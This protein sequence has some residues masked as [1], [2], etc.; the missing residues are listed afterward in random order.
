MSIIRLDTAEDHR[1]AYLASRKLPAGT[2]QQGR[3]IPRPFHETMPAEACTELGAEPCS[4]P[5]TRVGLILILL[6][7][8]LVAV[9]VAGSLA[10]FWPA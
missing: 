8:P 7:W 10:V 3:Y 1:A 4:P 5:V 2:D 6:G 9:L